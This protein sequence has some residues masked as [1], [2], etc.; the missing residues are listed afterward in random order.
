[1]IIIQYQHLNWCFFIHNLGGEKIIMKK[2][3]WLLLFLFALIL[4]PSMKVNAQTYMESFNEYY[5]WIPNTYINK[6]KNGETKYQQLTMITRKSDNQYVYCIEPGQLLNGNTTYTGTDENQLAVVNMT[7]AQ[8]K[9]VKLLAYY[10]YGYGNHTDIKWYS[11]TQFMIWKTVPN[12]YDIYWTST[13]NGTRIDKYTSEIAEMETLVANHSKT[14]NFNTSSLD[15]VIG[16][17]TSL[18]DANGVLGEYQIVSQNGV[19]ATKSGNTLNVTATSVGDGSLTLQKFDTRFNHPTI[20]Y[21]SP[22]SQDLLQVGS[23][24][25]LVMGINIK[26]TGGKVT[27]NKVDSDT[28]TAV[29][30]GDATLKGATYGVFKEDGTQIATIKTDEKGYVQ[31]DYLPAIGKM[32]LKELTASNGY[33]LDD[34]KYDFEVT[35]DNLY[36][37][38]QVQEKVIKRDVT[39]FKE[40]ASDKTGIMTG[41][42]NVKFSVT[43]KSTGKVYTEVTTNDKG[44]ITTTLPYGTYTIHQETATTNYSKVEDFEIV[45]NKDSDSPIYRVISNAEIQAKLKVIKVDKDTGEVINRSG[46]I[47]KIK[48]TD[49]GEYVCQTVTYPKATTLCEFKTDDNGVLIT[50]NLLHSGHYQLEEVDQKIDGYVWNKESQLFEIGENSKL[51]TDNIY[52]ILFEVK[53]DNKEV[54]GQV[55]ITK[56]GE[57]ITYTDNSYSYDTIKLDGVKFGLYASED[58]YSANGVLEFKKG[59]LVTTITTDENGTATIKD[60]YLG[61]Y[62]LVEM[63]SSHD[64]VIDSTK[65]AIDLKYKDQYTATIETSLDLKNHLAKGTLEFT[66]TDFSTSK[67]LPNTLIEIYTSNDRLVYSGRTDEN[68][69]IVITDLPVG[70]YYILEK[71]APTGYNLNDSKMEFEIKIDGEIVKSTLK[72]ELIVK[73][74]NTEKVEF[75]V[76]DSIALIIG[77]LGLGVIIYAKKHHKK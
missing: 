3:K 29:A 15:M 22:T 2:L 4:M 59:S 66:K 70:K 77:L 40:Y 47:F 54:K 14:P 62:Y 41:E 76:V 43:L 67:T 16:N 7:Q 25:P 69:K 5:K 31:S 33:E 12:G 71:E 19:T 57:K 35:T 13:L 6:T 9:R 37:T 65:H 45:V 58:I 56:T 32:Y 48:N 23:Y 39:F 21:P 10:G 30:Q 64:N 8:W 34:A 61:K 53:F 72:D 18:N 28:G 1:M 27:V 63:E 49:T 55:D 36:P 42:A 68:G 11:V 44:Y 60:L 73:A 38:V 26:V 74:P 24:D 75:P 17:T 52:G 46:I 50:P 51:I 20:V